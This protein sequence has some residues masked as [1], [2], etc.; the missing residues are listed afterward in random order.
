MKNKKPIFIVHSIAACLLLLFVSCAGNPRVI[1][2]DETT[3]VSESASLPAQNKVT[4]CA[5]GDNLIHIEII[6]DARAPDGTPSGG[7]DFSPIYAQI[8]PQIES[9]DIAF[10]NM[11]TISAGAEFGFSGYP[12]FNAPTELGDAVYDT[13]F[14]I[15]NHATNHALD[16][17]AAALRKMIDFWEE[18]NITYLGVFADEK[19]RAAPVIINK[20]NISFGFLSYTYGT[21]GLPLPKDSP[22]LVALIDT[23]VMAREIA[24][25]RPLCDYLIVSMHWGDE[26]ETV[27]NASQEKLAQFLAEQ[28]V[29]M[30]LGHHP[31]V[32]QEVR[33]V[34][35]PDGVSMVVFF[36]L[37]NFVSAQKNPQT[38]LGGMAR[39]VVEKADK[40]AQ[41]SAFE[42]IPLVTH[43]EKDGSGFRVIP[44]ADYTEELALRHGVGVLDIVKMRER[45]T[46]ISD[47]RPVR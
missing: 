10:I 23:E 17:G 30:V 8:K 36:S 31:H 26:Y 20:N 12:T 3:V 11:E 25:L 18:R 2:S 5:V 16:K 1:Q 34:K 6:D 7:F 29:D 46:A 14:D 41:T 4:L 39:V 33:A 27:P 47:V 44:L 42:L 45:I 21:N 15:V 38:M 13:G 22:Y 37:G 43:Y 24:A 40:T 19:K 35:R 9:A 32:L 28:N